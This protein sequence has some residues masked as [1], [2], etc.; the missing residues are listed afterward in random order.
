M[1]IILQIGMVVVSILGIV[2]LIMAIFFLGLLTMVTYKSY[3]FFKKQKATLKEVF[4]IAK[5]LSALK[6]IWR[7]RGMGQ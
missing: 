1:D 4:N 2:F 6:N 3:K 5:K 7:T